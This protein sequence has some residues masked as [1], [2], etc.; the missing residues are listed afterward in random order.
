MIIPGTLSDPVYRKALVAVKKF[1]T[2]KSTYGSRETAKSR[3]NPSIPSRG[4]NRF[5]ELARLC[6]D[7][8]WNIENYIESVFFALGKSV[9]DIIG[10]DLLSDK[11]KDRYRK[12]LSTGGGT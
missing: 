5:Y 7:E 2:M 1:D 12:V 11:A 6:I 3:D 4:F 10:K 8:G 9:P